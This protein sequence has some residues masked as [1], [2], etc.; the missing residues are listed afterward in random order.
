MADTGA[1]VGAAVLMGSPGGMWRAAKRKR[2]YAGKKRLPGPHRRRT[3]GNAKTFVKKIHAS[4]HPQPP[5][6]LHRQIRH[7]P[8]AK[9]FHGPYFATASSMNWLHVGWKRQC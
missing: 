4:S 7:K 1:G 8:L 6:G 2:R 9:P 3:P 5:H